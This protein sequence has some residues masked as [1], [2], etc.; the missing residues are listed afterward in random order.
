LDAAC[1]QFVH[2]R[3]QV[4]AFVLVTGRHT[5]GERQPVCVDG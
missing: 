2:K 4:P 5:Y 1:E 3:Q